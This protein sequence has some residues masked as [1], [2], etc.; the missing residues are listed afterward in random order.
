[1]STEI[2]EFQA[3]INQLMSLIIN[4]FYSNKEIFLREL[5][6]NASDALDKIRYESLQNKEILKE[7][8]NFE[9]KI[10]TDKE[11][12]KLIIEDNGVGMTKEDLQKCLGTIANSGTK[13]FIQN[14]G[15]SKDINL[16][17]QFGVGFYSSYLVAD[18]VRVTT[19][20]NNDKEYIWESSA[21]GNYTITE[22]E[23]QELSRG[24]IIE[25]T[26]KDDS[27]EYLDV[28]R[29][30]DIIK[31][32]SE[33]IQY[34]IKVY[35]QKTK[36]EEVEIEDSNENKEED[37]TENNDDVKI[38]DDKESE[39]KPKE[40]KTEKITKTYYEYD[41]IN[42]QEPIWVKPTSEITDDE[43][44][45]FY[46]SLTG[47]YGD[48]MKYKHISVEGAVNFKA[49]IYIPACAPMNLFHMERERKDVKLYV[50]RV[51]ITDDCD[52]LVPQW[53]NFVKGVVDSDDIPLNVSREMLQQNKFMKLI[54]KSLTK[55]I[56]EMI[57]EIKNESDDEY[58][59]FFLSFGKN[60]KLGLHEDTQ[61]EDKLIELLKFR[62]SKSDNK[63]ITFKQ[64]TENVKE[65]FG[66]VHEEK[67]CECEK[68]C[69]EECPCENKCKD[70]CK[71]KYDQ[72]K[73]PSTEKVLDQKYKNIYYIVGEDLD[74]V[75]NSP[76]VQGFTKYGLEVVYMTEAIDEYLMKRLTQYHD[77]KFMNI[78][79]N[80]VDMSAYKEIDSEKENKE[81]EKLI[82]FLQKT[83]DKKVNKIKISNRLVDVPC[84][85]TTDN[86]GWSANMER[87]MN[88][89][90]LGDNQMKQFMVSSKTLEINVEHPIM[91][92][93]EN[94]IGDEKREVGIKDVIELMFNG[95]LLSSGFSIEKPQLFVNR[96]NRM[97][98]FG[99]AC[100]EKSLKENDDE[101]K[102]VDLNVSMEEN[103]M[104]NVD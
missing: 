89:Q 104:E 85:I 86:F 48:P 84:M 14:I 51:F 81:H 77:F 50:K 1:M 82:E 91:K 47:D 100:D 5:I 7:N 44:K 95:A 12:N 87:I 94:S 34:P 55:K 60:I 72:V 53:L 62:T 101:K 17:G 6:S 35:T 41:Q 74:S 96:L 92:N 83:L 76:F 24:T 54:K 67:T 22:T 38:E 61:Y 33:Y 102:E 65:Q 13:Q 10:R 68:E 88:S 8:S 25:L 28:D 43:Y 73:E 11:N 23:N 4:A 66:T 98:E 3:E 59:K 36:E 27:K 58:M 93:I 80:D 9:I 79:N 37:K 32:H 26:L 99:L 97:I 18:N 19:K 70:E 39:E 75:Q 63:Y 29:I 78:C 56:I 90:V 2:F 57:E 71:C 21:N 30:K 69:K 40:K 20:H 103:N 49:L 46:K 42:T 45:Q 64:Y 16:I 31:K 15:K 52:N